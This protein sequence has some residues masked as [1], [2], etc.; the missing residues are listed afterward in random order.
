M[1]SRSVLWTVFAVLLGVL[2]FGFATS[3][4]FAQP[5]WNGEGLERLEWLVAAYLAAALLLWWIRPALFVPC[6]AAFALFD[7]VA[8]VGFGPVAAAAFLSS[9]ALLLGDAFL[10]R[11]GLRR[12]VRPFLESGALAFLAGIAWIAF[13]IGVAAHWPVNHRAIYLA[14]LSVPIVAN[15]G[16]IPYYAAGFA[17]AL[18]PSSFLRPHVF[19]A[20]ALASF[21]VLAQLL[22][23]VKP[24]VGYDGLAVH[25]M[26]PSYVAIHH[27]WPFDPA[28]YIWAVSPMA[29]DWLY[30]TAYLLGGEFAARLMNFLLLSALLAILYCFGRRYL[31]RASA[32]LGVS[33]FASVPLVQLV[34]GSLF[35]EN[36]LAVMILAALLALDRFHATRRPAYLMLLGLFLGTALAAK[37]GAITCALPLAGFAVAAAARP[38]RRP[39]LR[40]GLAA[41]LVAL[42]TGVPA[43]ALAW[44]KTGS[45]IYPYASPLFRSPFPGGSIP[46]WDS[47]YQLTFHSHRFLESQDGSMGFQFLLLLPLSLA[48]FGRRTAFTARAALAAALVSGIAVLAVQPYLRYLYPALALA[49]VSFL[50]FAGAVRLRDPSFF[51][52]LG[53]VSAG[54]VLLNLYFLPSSGWYEK[55]FYLSPL[56]ARSESETYI[57][58]MAPVRGLIAYLNLESPGAPVWFIGTNHI[59]GLIGRSWVAAWHQPQF[60]AAVA[61]VR[62]DGDALRLANERGIRF[63][64]APADLKEITAEPRTVGAFLKDDTVKEYQ[65]G[66]MAVYRLA[67]PVVTEPRR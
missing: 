41:L 43:Y 29:G 15:R 7:A 32:L 52:A 46:S 62:S 10:E 12:E 61:S 58:T 47:L 27:F 59:A 19:A 45:T 30:T 54:L 42:L 66:S 22:V 2:T 36:F 44:W 8:T 23:A 38:H 13:A 39:L 26:L 53:A 28:Q 14:A 5:V 48:L 21:A 50:Y 9:S 31:H 11:L 3:H 4:L 51:K 25:L 60:S 64:V 6:L 63:F 18:R 57:R 35:I 49:S 17:R 20:G 37:F 67:A 1:H 56:D 16:A 34:T 40:Y 55:G 65:Y 33:L 24:E